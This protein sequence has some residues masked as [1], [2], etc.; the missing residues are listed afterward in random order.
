MTPP[1]LL[2]VND[3]ARRLAVSVPTIR[4]WCR[5]GRIAFKRLP[6]GALRFEP[7]EI[8]RLELDGAVERVDPEPVPPN[9]G[10]EIR[11]RFPFL[12]RPR[13]S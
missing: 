13:N 4:R 1:P 5:E 9:A 12:K 11:E 2:T 7:D 3:V 6:S 8:L 10:D